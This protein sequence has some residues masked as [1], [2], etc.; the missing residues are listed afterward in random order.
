MERTITIIG[1]SLNRPKYTIV[2][3]TSG[4]YVDVYHVETSN[5]Y[6]DVEHKA[7]ISAMVGKSFAVRG[8]VWRK[9]KNGTFYVKA[10]RV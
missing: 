8:I 6:D 3:I 1:E 9:R 10:I 5:I 4:E 7:D 2:E